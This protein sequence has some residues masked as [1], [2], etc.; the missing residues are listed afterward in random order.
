MVK[1]LNGVGRLLSAA[2]FSL[3]SLDES[4]LLEKASRSTGL[5]D[6]GDPAFHEPLRRLL[7]SLESEA[8]LNAIGRIIAQRDLVRTLENRMWMLEERRL[9]P[10]IAEEKV[11]QPLFIIGLPRSGTSILH[12]LMAQDPANRT[13]MTWEVMWPHPRPRV[14]TYD[15]DPRIAKAD[16]YLKGVDQLIPGFKSMHAMGSQLPQECCMLMNHEFMSM[17]L[18]CSFRIT[19][20]QDWLDVQDMTPVYESHKEQLKYFQ[21]LVPVRKQWVLKS[22][23]HLWSLGAL[24][25]VYPDAQIVHTHR[26]PVKVAASIASL[27]S[28]L[29]GMS[30]DDVD[31]IEN[32]AD[33]AARV[34]GGLQ[35]TLDVRSGIENED[36]QF[37]D[38]YF[39][40]F[41]NDPIAMVGRIYRHFGRELDAEAESRMRAFL[42]ANSRKLR[43]KHEY[44]LKGAGLDLSSE[45]KRFQAYQE[46]F[47]V[48]SE[49]IVK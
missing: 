32:G 47:S 1:G 13:P 21:S 16:L 40:D 6:Y 9:H 14:E 3:T 38:M 31:P 2:G 26:D 17:Q 29:R 23:Q 46:R 7:A 8:D 20:F 30:T 11:A 10:E 41:M 42:A 33:W 18:H 24:L 22:P 12:E 15:S 34:A 28:L 35:E 27:V 25:R 49:D 48:P 43:G 44:T 37:F 36:V 39:G 45:R 4:V 5:S 19:A